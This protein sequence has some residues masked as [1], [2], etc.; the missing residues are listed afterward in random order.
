MYRFLPLMWFM[1]LAGC[2]GQYI[3]GERGDWIPLGSGGQ[4]EV[5][6]PVSVPPGR[7]R[8]FLQRGE[9][10][11]QGALNS[12]DA[13]CSFELREI[14]GDAARIEPGPILIENIEIGSESVVEIDGTLIAGRALLGIWDS[15]PSIHRF[16][17]FRLL[18]PGQPELLSLTCRGALADQPYA[19]L[20]TLTEIRGA[21]GTVVE[22]ELNLE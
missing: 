15:G 2:G 17:R 4:L 12:Y 1:L 22:L 8:A 6:H 18:S 20:P 21:L 7:A 5:R 19:E 3:Q 13:S 16:Y 11:P 10:I 14:A 9:V